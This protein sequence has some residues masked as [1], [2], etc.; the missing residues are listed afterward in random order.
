M[1]SI[2]PQEI[3]RL[4]RARQALLA[5]RR[6]VDDEILRRIARVAH[7][8]KRIPHDCLISVCNGRFHP[9]PI[10]RRRCGH[11]AGLRRRTRILGA[12][13]RQ[14]VD[15]RDHI[16]QL[17]RPVLKRV[18]L[19]GDAAP[20]DF[21]HRAVGILHNVKLAVITFTQAVHEFRV[22]LRFRLAHQRLPGR[23][24]QHCRLPAHRLNN[25]A[26]EILNQ[27]QLW[28]GIKRIDRHVE[29]DR[30]KRQPILDQPTG[31]RFAVFQIE[32]RRLLVLF[33]HRRAQQIDALGKVHFAEGVL[34]VLYRLFDAIGE[35]DLSP[36]HSVMD[37]IDQDKIT[38]IDR[39]TH[40]LLL[41]G[42]RRL[43]L[44][45]AKDEIVFIIDGRRLNLA[46]M[47]YISVVF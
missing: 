9:F 15:L 18:L 16:D 5:I 2:I 36:V 6:H 47:G 40:G 35:H 25:G 33:K 37:A 28:D 42:F 30:D 4:K 1:D 39:F 11:Q 34:N 41:V 26:L 31:G 7:D 10:D 43:P 45:L 38:I 22:R 14:I 24:L 19:A 13:L 23:A 44:R 21:S 46:L 17:L 32:D 27:F 20:A 29:L 8:L 3:G 12:A